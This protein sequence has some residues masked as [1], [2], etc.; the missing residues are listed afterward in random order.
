MPLPNP[1][2]IGLPA[3]VWLLQFLLVLTFSL[4]LVPM[5]LT[6][7]GSLIALY[8]EVRSPGRREG[9][10]RRLARQLWQWLPAITSFTITLGVAPLLFV[11]LVYGKFFY[12]AS[13]LTGWS[14]FAVI[15]LLLLGYGMLYLQAMGQLRNRGRFWAG[16]VAVLTFLAVAAIYVSTMSLTT[17]PQVWKALYA[18]DQSGMHWFF[19][20][21][22]WLHVLTGALAL[23]G[24]L[25]ALWGHLAR[26]AAYGRFARRQG[27][28]WM[29]LALIA[30]GPVGVWYLTTIPAAGRA[31]VAGW[32][33]TLAG[34]TLL[35][36]FGLFL[37]AE[38]RERRPMLAWAGMG[39]LVA[40]SVLLA[41][42]R[43]LVRQ[44]LLAPH[45]TNAD[46]RI[47]PQ[48]DVFLI[49]AVMLVSALSL[50][51]YLVYRFLT[52]PATP[53]QRAVESAD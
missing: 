18:A 30:G 34:L 2:P 52:T 45:V 53:V 35:L 46:W 21:P 41:V 3:P 33:L 1:E 4:H 43:H 39:A 12:P 38:R 15:P 14:W 20:L 37:L 13:V 9:H 7:G 28:G 17:E 22:R 31:A 51:G 11:Q 16:L 25:V 10:H 27:L 19:K 32:L 36:G 42:Q 6:V 50:I 29:T 40:G 24:G 48:W 44:A 5:S 47:Q 49:F 26:D 23:S 8:C